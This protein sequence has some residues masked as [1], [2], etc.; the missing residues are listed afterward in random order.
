VNPILI[1]SS[2]RVRDFLL[3]TGGGATSTKVESFYVQDDWR[4]TRNF[5]IKLGA[6]WD[7]QQANGT[8][9]SYIKLNNMWHNLQPRVGF[10]W[11]FHRVRAESKLFANYARYIETPLPLDINVRAGGDDIQLDRN[12][13]VNFLNAAPNTTIFQGTAS[14]PWLPWLRSDARGCEPETAVGQ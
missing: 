5:Q 12:A 10:T 8:N 7:Y 9:S 6:R 14:G 4:L 3:N 13:N 2:V 11:D 1:L